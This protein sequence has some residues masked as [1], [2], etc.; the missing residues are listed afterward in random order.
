ML[1][2]NFLI[3]RADLDDGL[4]AVGNESREKTVDASYLLLPCPLYLVA[5][6]RQP[7]VV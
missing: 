3:F 7:F 5:K 4:Q 1:L 2:K 6:R